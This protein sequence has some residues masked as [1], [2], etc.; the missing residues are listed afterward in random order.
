MASKSPGLSLHC[1]PSLSLSFPKCSVRDIWDRVTSEGPFYL[2]AHTVFILEQLA[3]ETTGTHAL[4]WPI[5]AQPAA[6]QTPEGS[7]PRAPAAPTSKS[8]FS[9]VRLILKWYHQSVGTDLGE[10]AA[11][12]PAGQPE[13]F[14]LKNKCLQ[15]Q[16]PHHQHPSLGALVRRRRRKKTKNKK[17]KKEGSGESPLPPPASFPLC[18][19]K[20]ITDWK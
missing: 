3:L 9:R 4:S 2:H 15:L 17:R 7:P 14:H 6:P 13:G 10:P 1:P 11:R 8:A 16:P 20:P 12:E 19:T 5:R 18:S